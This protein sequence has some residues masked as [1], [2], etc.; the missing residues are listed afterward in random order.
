MEVVEAKYE[1]LGECPTSADEAL[2]WIEVAGRTAYQSQDKITRD[3]AKAF[4]QM[5]AKRGHYSVLEHSNLVLKK[6]G[7]VNIAD[8]V[9][10]L[11]FPIGY[12]TPFHMVEMANGYTYIGGNFRAWLEIPE[13]PREIGN[14]VF[15]FLRDLIS[16]T[17]EPSQETEFEIVTDPTEIPLGMRRIMVRFIAPRGVTHEFVRH[18]R[19]IGITQE[20]T[21]F[22]KYDNI[23]VHQPPGLTEAQE[24]LW[25]VEMLRTEETYR[26]LVTTGCSAQIA[27]SVLPIALKAELVA[28][29]DIAEWEHIFNLRTSAGA[30]PEI[31]ALMS[32]LKADFMNRG[33]L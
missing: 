20:S 18:R 13:I 3:S 27:R 26:S 8:T 24:S 17:V 4:C 28:T 33:W 11:S 10:D 6:K 25:K 16:K 14:L 29:A 31:R 1:I 2:K 15:G 5:I 22:V 30:H 23:Q 19:R 32:P 21:R 12:Y 7:N 9:G